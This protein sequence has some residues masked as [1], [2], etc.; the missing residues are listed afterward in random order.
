MTTWAIE[1]PFGPTYPKF[2]VPAAVKAA[3]SAAHGAYVLSKIA[4]LQLASLD[5]YCKRG[6]AA[7]A[8]CPCTSGSW[9]SDGL[10]I[11]AAV[12]R[13]HRAALQ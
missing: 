8:P 5:S 7:S 12:K 1:A 3:G 10:K 4:A 11:L 13:Q 9:E 6:S 2:V